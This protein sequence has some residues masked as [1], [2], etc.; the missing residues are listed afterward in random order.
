MSG[1]GEQLRVVTAGPR[2]DLG[3]LNL[4]RDVFAEDRWFITTGDEFGL[5][6]LQMQARIDQHHACGSSGVWVARGAHGAVCG[7]LF[8]TGGRLQRMRHT[9]KIEVMVA[10]AWRGQG[11]GRALLEGCIAWAEASA[12]VEKLGLA[13]FA[14]N[15]AAIGLYERCGFVEEGRRLREYR[16]EDGSYR[17]DVLMCRATT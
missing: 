1:E 2:D 11:V 7:V 13:V 8:A 6:L 17:D 10:R 14:D 16:M 3:I 5:D 12:V 9:S 15:E 4:Y